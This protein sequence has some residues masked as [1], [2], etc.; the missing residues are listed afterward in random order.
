VTS[1]SSQS[2]T[3]GEVNAHGQQPFPPHNVRVG[4]FN[5]LSHNFTIELAALAIVEEKRTCQEPF[6]DF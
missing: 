1:A 6:S 5:P 4:S 2:R 3:E